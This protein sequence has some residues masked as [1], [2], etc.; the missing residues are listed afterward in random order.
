MTTGRDDLSARSRMTSLHRGHRQPTVG[1]KV[2]NP[3]IF[4]A[5]TFLFDDYEAM[6]TRSNWKAG[7]RY[8]YGLAGADTVRQLEEMLADIEG[9]EDAIASGSGMSA[10]A[11]PFLTFLGS[12]DHV[13]ITDSVY[14]PVRSL[15]N[16][17]LKRMGIDVEY[18]DSSITPEALEGLVRPAT[19]LIYLESPGSVTFEIQDVQGIAALARRKGILTALDNTWATPF[20]YRPIEHGVD[21]VIHAATKYIGGA[22]DLMMGIVAGS[23]ELVHRMA[24]AQFEYG[25]YA[26]PDDAYACIRGLRSMAVRM[27]I[28]LESSLK[29]AEHLEHQP[30]IADILHPAKPGDSMHAR[31]VDQGFTGGGGLFSV[32]FTSNTK[33]EFVADVANALTLFGMGYS[34]GGFESLISAQMPAGIR[35]ASVWPRATLSNGTMLR[36]NIG[37]EDPADLIADIDQAFAIARSKAAQ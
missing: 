11:I 20:Y 5:S 16:N 6:T 22:S 24:K 21:L 34:W 8:P 17:Q 10:C 30:E 1:Y 28:H 13:L 7:E 26:N 33:D 3:P 15:A 25:Y 14:G 9:A 35:T 29:I 27:P 23:K 32:I 12:G 36:F 19:K 18:F 37:L 4:R 31:F 2:V